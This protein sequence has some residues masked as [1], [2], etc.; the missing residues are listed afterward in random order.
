MAASQA[1]IQIAFNSILFATDFSPVSDAALS[2]VLGLARCYDSKVI[3]THV[4]P[5]EPAAGLGRVPPSVY[6]DLEE[7]EAKQEL[8]RYD[9]RGIFTG[10]RHEFIVER[11]YPPAIVPGLIEAEHVDLVVLGTHGRKGLSKLFSGSVAEQIFRKAACPVLTVGPA[12]TAVPASKWIPSRILLATDFSTGSLHALPYAL[13]LAEDAKAELVLFHAAQLVPWEQQSEMG[14][15]YQKR[16]RELL[17]PDR[18]PTRCSVSREVRFDLPAPA[19]LSFTGE[20]K[21]DLIVMGVHRALAPVLDAHV[22]WTT[23]CEVISEA[24]CPVLT[25]RA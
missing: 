5:F 7:Q 3:V 10:L 9:E 1:S 20:K 8:Q 6:L 23:A 17:P 11:G 25:V 12:V 19:I 2:F 13:T 16:L 21:V 4:V 18:Q 15:H 24:L 22:P 14:T